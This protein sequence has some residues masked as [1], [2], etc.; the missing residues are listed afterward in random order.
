MIIISI[1]PSVRATGQSKHNR[2]Y[3][4]VCK[5][6][7]EIDAIET[8]GETRTGKSVERVSEW[9]SVAFVVYVTVDYMPLD[10]YSI[11]AHLTANNEFTS[12]KMCVRTPSSRYRLVYLQCTHSVIH[13]FIYKIKSISTKTYAYSFAAIRH[14]R[15]TRSDRFSSFKWNK[16]YDHW[17]K[18]EI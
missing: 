5:L 1:L 15:H 7:G 13:D 4:F 10:G 16:W 6:I 17:P 12:V 14:A 2:L 9:K 18:R 8:C 3:L 11:A